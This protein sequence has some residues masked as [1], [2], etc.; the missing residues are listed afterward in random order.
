MLELED[1]LK[2]S[3]DYIEN[4]YCRN[5]RAK[6]QYKD[7]KKRAGWLRRT[8][9]RSETDSSVDEADAQAQA[10]EQE[11]KEDAEETEIVVIKVRHGENQVYLL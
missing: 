4:I 10:I 1:L 2:S 5:K 7:V 8:F 11:E 9:G 6:K 3:E